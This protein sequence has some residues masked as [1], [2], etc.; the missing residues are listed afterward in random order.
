MR[1]R[2]S[3]TREQGAALMVAMVMI[4]V[5]SLLGVSAMRSG[6]MEG[7]MVANTFEKDLTFQA[8]ESATDFII[9]DDTNLEDVICLPN[10]VRSDVNQLE[11]GAILE[12]TVD[13]LYGGESVAIGYSL[14][15]GFTA[16]RF[17]A[18]GTSTLVESGTASSITQGVFLIGAKSTSGG[19]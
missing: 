4:F 6:T 2:H 7:R 11:S 1:I 13:V 3:C 18:S 12:T 14:D 19:C 9:A 17:T 16:M 10:A 5:M 15:S 8:A